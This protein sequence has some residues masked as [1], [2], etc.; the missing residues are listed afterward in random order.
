M[1]WQHVT[2]TRTHRLR[3]YARRRR[4]SISAGCLGSL[5]AV[6]LLWL[7]GDRF[8][9]AWSQL[10]IELKLSCSALISALV[11]IV[12]ALP[13]PLEI[14]IEHFPNLL[15]PLRRGWVLLQELPGLV[16]QHEAEIWGAPIYMETDCYTRRGDFLKQIHAQIETTFAQN[17]RAYV[18][19]TGIKGSGKAWEAYAY[20]RAY[21]SMY[22][23]ILWID[24]S[25]PDEMESS[26]RAIIE[27]WKPEERAKAVPE[28]SSLKDLPIEIIKKWLRMQRRHAP[29]QQGLVILAGYHIGLEEDMHRQVAAVM[30]CSGQNC[31]LLTTEIGAGAGNLP[32]YITALDLPDWTPEEAT[33]FLLFRSKIVRQTPDGHLQNATPEERRAAGEIARTLSYLALALEYAG[34]YIAA[35]GCT[36]EAYLELYKRER[37]NMLIRLPPP[38]VLANPP[39]ANIATTW[40]ASFK[41]IASNNPTAASLLQLCAYFTPDA[42]PEEIIRD[43][44]NLDRHLQPVVR[45]DFDFTEALQALAR[46]SLIKWDKST[47]TLIVHGMV[48]TVIQEDVYRDQ[49][50]VDPLITPQRLRQKALERII[51][52]MDSALQRRRTRVLQATRFMQYYLPHIRLCVRALEQYAGNRYVRCKEALELLVIAGDYLL[53]FAQYQ[54]AEEVLQLAGEVYQELLDTQV[55]PQASPQGAEYLR[56]LADWHCTRGY[57]TKAEQGYTEAL[58]MYTDLGETTY[59]SQMITIQNNRAQLHE[60]WVEIE[61]GRAGRFEPDY[62]Q[63]FTA[64]LADYRQ[65][66]TPDPTRP[67]VEQASLHY[68]CL[69]TL[70]IASNLAWWYYRHDKDAEIKQLLN[71][72]TGHFFQPQ[73][74][75]AQPARPG[76]VRPDADESASWHIYEQLFEGM[77][78]VASVNLQEEARAHRYTAEHHHHLAILYTNHG[79]KARAHTH[80]EM[81]AQIDVCYYGSDSSHP[82][83]ALRLNNQAVLYRQQQK[84]GSSAFDVLHQALALCRQQPS[85]TAFDHHRLAY[86]VA[87]NLAALYADQGLK[88]QA[89]TYE[90]EARRA[91]E[92]L[93]RR[94]WML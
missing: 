85:S 71:E 3:S 48:Q 67:A 14:M 8:I 90:E 64:S 34:A 93:D 5:V 75:A 25:S 23:W 68:A 70:S 11:Q 16:L 41:Q 73:L 91:K 15:L 10:A 72:M 31:V 53:E 79:Q 52:G 94:I 89:H 59:P 57:Y 50:N 66:R 46:Y 81:V 37:Q 92:E 29:G 62:Q 13:E 77:L 24:V 80:F 86:H 38:L 45:N 43:A 58:A 26:A 36:L 84:K 7:L 51:L 87:R 22:R 19:I 6:A 39:W 9:S 32:A 44:P 49:H 55:L 82:N 27:R 47:G 69:R 30:T 74:P 33:A 78:D 88:E 12:I 35:S 17:R 18:A 42:I 4:R 56:C 76:K 65:L 61:Q 54:E 60:Q 21:S 28:D 83:I 20:A 63:A 40:A 2:A 1:G